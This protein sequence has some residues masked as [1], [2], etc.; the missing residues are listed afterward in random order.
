MLN[1]YLFDEGA[2]WC[3][4]QE[5]NVMQAGSLISKG[6]KCRFFYL[7]K[8]YTGTVLEKSGKSPLI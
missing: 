1:W 6:D 4:V 8:E 7:G 2:G 3:V 5:K